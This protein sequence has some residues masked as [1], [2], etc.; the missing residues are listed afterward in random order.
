M[1]RLAG[2]GVALLIIC[3]VALSACSTS[4]SEEIQPTP[5]LPPTLEPTAISMPTFTPTAEPTATPIVARS[6]TDGDLVTVHYVGTL[7]NGDI[8]DTSAGRDPLTFTLGRG[9][10]IPGF[11]DA[12][13]GL[14]VGETIT[15]RIEPAQAYGEHREDL[16]LELPFIPE[17]EGVVPGDRVRLASGTIALVLEVT[18]E[19]VRVDAN[20]QLAGEALN[21]IIELMSIE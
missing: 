18:E 20:H 1:R 6:A 4:S 8:F 17:A 14:S 15:V 2:A 3:S 11:E 5:T 12:I 7:D 16:I 9:R 13:H 21:F 10:M 19:M